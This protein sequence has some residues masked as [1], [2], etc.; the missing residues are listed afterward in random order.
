MRASAAFALALTACAVDPNALPEM[1]FDVPESEV[2]LEPVP[3]PALAPG[4]GRLLFTNNLD[5]TVTLVDLDAALDGNPTV[6]GTVPVGF[7]PVEREGPHHLT[8]DLAAEFYYVGISNFVPGSGS[9]PHG[10]HGAGTADGH[11]LKLRVSDNTLAA[12]VRIA[13]NPGDV[14][15]TPDGTKLLATHFDL[16]KITEAG[17]SGITSGP[18]LDSSLAIV[19]PATMTR[20]ALVPACPAAHG[21][22][23][24]ADSSTAIMSCVSD[25]AAIVDLT[26]D[27]H[28][29]TRVPV[30]DVP[31]TAAAPSCGPYAVT[32]HGST[33]WI[34]CYTGGGR[35]VAVDVPAKERAGREVLLGGNP[36]FGD[37]LGDVMV[38]AHQNADGVTFI[39]PVNATVLATKILAPSVCVL[40]HV[41]RFSEDGSRVFVVCEGNKSSAGSLVVLDGAGDHEVLGS[42]ALGIFP[43]DIALARRQP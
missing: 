5:D 23:I 25:E 33:A 10:I 7:V 12:S 24:T 32:L 37:V 16:L 27:A 34:S 22:A 43:D 28:D 21:I 17:A 38:I 40:P 35:L 30:L 36:V 1:T 6:M 20:V 2:W 29:V 19:D 18:E 14:R 42:V 31:G 13:R 39:D 41:A 9:G 11:L 26:S 4:E 3:V 8:V 15:L